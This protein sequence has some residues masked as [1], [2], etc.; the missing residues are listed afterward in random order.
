[1]KWGFPLPNAGLSVSSGGRYIS[2]VSRGKQFLPQ[3]GSAYAQQVY[4]RD[5]SGLDN[6]PRW[7]GS[8]AGNPNTAFDDGDQPQVAVG[9]PLHKVNTATLNLLLQGTLFRMPTLGPTLA[10]RLTCNAAA[11]ELSSGIFGRNWSFNSGSGQLGRHVPA[12]LLD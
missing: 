9:L 10:L 3:V 4:V 12:Q 6:D 2:I 11:D 5:R 7:R 1:M 8:L